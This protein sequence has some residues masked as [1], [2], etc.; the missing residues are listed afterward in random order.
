MIVTFCGHKDVFDAE[1]IKNRLISIVKQLI[2]EGA[3]TFYL[4]GYG[5]FDTLAARVIHDLKPSFPDIRS[6]LIIPYINRNYDISLYDETLYPPLENV[7]MKFAIK[8]R[9]EWMV[10]RSEIVVSYV[11]HG[12]GGAAT[13]LAYAE[14]KKK[15]II[16]IAE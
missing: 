6:L 11:L 12:W 7:P 10:D 3:D 14:R 4:G 13:T 5:M 2:I 8:R 16:Y 1:T 9:N 15:R